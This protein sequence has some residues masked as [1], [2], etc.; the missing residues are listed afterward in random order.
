VK[1]ITLMFGTMK[2][3]IA[4]LLFASFVLAG[5]ASNNV[6]LPAIEQVAPENVEAEAYRYKVIELIGIGEAYEAK[7]NAEGIKY[8]DQY[9]Q[10]TAKRYD[11]E[12]LAA[13]TGISVKRLLDWANYSELMTLNKIGPKNARLLEAAGVDSTKELA[14]RVI[15]NLYPALE[16]ANSAAKPNP[17]V[18]QMPTKTL[19]GNW[20]QTAKDYKSIVE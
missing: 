14:K 1:G 20:V 17:I 13:K 10:A 19:V 16:K 9:L 8:V 7:L 11:R 18:K 12:K 3:S 15:E 6:Q 4:S 2:K 5:C